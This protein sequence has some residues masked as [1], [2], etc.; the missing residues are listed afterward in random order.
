LNKKLPISISENA[1]FKILEIRTNKRI[2]QDYHLRLGVKSAGCGIASYVIGF[3][4]ANEKDVIYKL[5]EFTVIIEKI[6]VMHL[7][8][9]TIDYGDVDGETGF[10]F[11]DN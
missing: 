11:R 6:Q 10:I 9:K 5:N 3:D 4:H 1:I 2:T 8:G 7:A